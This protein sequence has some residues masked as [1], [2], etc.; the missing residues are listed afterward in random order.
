MRGRLGRRRALTFVAVRII[1]WS[2]ED[3]LNKALKGEKTHKRRCF[4]YTK[5]QVPEVFRD[6]LNV[7]MRTGFD[8][9][10]KDVEINLWEIARRIR[11]KEA[12]YARLVQK[13]FR[14]MQARRFLLIYMQE[15]VRLRDIRT[16]ASF[17]IQRLY[18]GCIGRRRAEQI[19]V[20]NYK[21][22]MLKS[23]LK[24]RRL[25]EDKRKAEDLRVK[26]LSKYSKERSEERTAR[27]I[28]LVHPSAAQGKKMAAF[29]D[30][31]YGCDSVSNLM[32]ELSSQA[33][34]IK[35][36][37]K[38]EEAE[39]AERAEFLRKEQVR[40]GKA[41]EIYFEDEMRQRSVDLIERMVTDMPVLN[42]AGLLKHHNDHH[43]GRSSFK[44]P[45][46]VYIEP[47]HAL[48][49]DTGVNP[50]D[51]HVA[52]E[53]RRKKRLA[54][55]ETERLAAERA[56]RRV[57]ARKASWALKLQSASTKIAASRAFG[58]NSPMK[59]LNPGA[60][61]SFD[62]ILL[63]GNPLVKEE[64]PPTTQIVEPGSSGGGNSELVGHDSISDLLSTAATFGSK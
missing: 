43:K 7:A 41:M 53:A 40:G 18:R 46:S 32:E 51:R 16:A 15:L 59:A 5:E 38:D 34:K 58:E 11:V 42:R 30:S 1:A 50:P 27:L 45:K 52:A 47:S 44:F 8:P 55:Q 61:N 48:Y 36:R 49:E 2:N 19:I 17:R 25:D 4:W 29:K 13:R 24:S 3:L 14:G 64:T 37:D 21:N 22:F 56:A 9:P 54:A 63:K 23:H 26:L 31:S 62:N 6:Y 39:R 60:G 12:H 20:A 28:G 33:L 35:K 57:E 10:R